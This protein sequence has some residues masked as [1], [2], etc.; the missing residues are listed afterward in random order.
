M[1]IYPLHENCYALLVTWTRYSKWNEILG[2][3]RLKLQ[4]R[5]ATEGSNSLANGVI[6]V[7]YWCAQNKC[8]IQLGSNHFG[9]AILSSNTSSRLLQCVW[10]IFSW[11]WFDVGSLTVELFEEFQNLRWKCSN[12]KGWWW[13]FSPENI[14]EGLVE[15]MQYVLYYHLLRAS[16]IICS[17]KY[18]WTYCSSGLNYLY[19]SLIFPFQM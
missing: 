9:S 15:A 7:M 19:I 18:C 13:Q 3:A 1:H 11:P 12:Q 14:F 5:E 4:N 2:V 10:Y 17:F 16:I 8:F 6:Y